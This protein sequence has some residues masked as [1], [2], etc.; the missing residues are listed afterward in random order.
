VVPSSA[1]LALT[2]RLTD[3]RIQPAPEDGKHVPSALHKRWICRMRVRRGAC[4]CLGLVRLSSEPTVR[5]STTDIE[6]SATSSAPKPTCTLP[7]TCTEV[8]SPS[9][10]TAMAPVDKHTV[11]R[12]NR[13]TLYSDGV[14]D[15]DA[16][17]V[18]ITLPG[19]AKRFMSMQVVSEDHY[20]TEVV[21]CPGGSSYLQQGQRRHALRLHHHSHTGKP[22]RRCRCKSRQRTAGSDPSG[23]ECRSGP[24]W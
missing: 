8:L 18:M 13:D 19:T 24:T 21:V 20:T 12:M 17:P 2:Q 14:I 22:R 10:D 23:G 11:V 6:A 3:Q 4:R 9:S 15:L 1:C 16:A 5:F 7:R